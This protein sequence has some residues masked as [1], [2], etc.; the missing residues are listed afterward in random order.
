MCA[1]A[2]KYRLCYV[3]LLHYNF[4]SVKFWA[5]RMCNEKKLFFQLSVERVVVRKKCNYFSSVK[6]IV[7]STRN[8]N[9]FFRITSDE[10]S[11][12]FFLKTIFALGSVPDN[13]SQNL[14][15]TRDGLM[16][17]NGGLCLVALRHNRS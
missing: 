11:T 14:F 6:S 10:F 16:A 2:I 12:R 9:I 15:S 13:G 7:F 17:C 5:R 8:E 3:P 4:S 1:K